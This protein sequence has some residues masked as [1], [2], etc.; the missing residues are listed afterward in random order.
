M[1]GESKS[2]AYKPIQKSIEISMSSIF[3]NHMYKN[4]KMSENDVNNEI[5]AGRLAPISMRTDEKTSTNNCYCPICY[6]F[7]P[8]INETMCCKKPIC[9]ECHAATCSGDCI[10]CRQRLQIRG[11]ITYNQLTDRDE[12][13]DNI[14]EPI[15]NLV[16][17][18]PKQKDMIIEFFN[19]GVSVC[20]IEST[21]ASI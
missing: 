7:Y 15:R 18:F 10:F 6:S 11:N 17:K 16:N 20:D 3:I 14:P 12:V 21:L 5:R 2:A 13:P 9:T 19:C 4:Y 1:N 8:R